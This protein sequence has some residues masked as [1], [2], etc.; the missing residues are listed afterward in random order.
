M[1]FKI[2]HDKIYQDLPPLTS[3]AFLSLLS[4]ASAEALPAEVLARAFRALPPLHENSKATLTR[5]LGSSEKYPYMNAVL[6]LARERASWLSAAEGEAEDLFMDTIVAITSSLREPRGRF[7]ET[8]WI[9]YSKQ[10]FEDAWRERF[11]RTGARR[12]PPTTSLS[13]SAD[14]ADVQH[15]EADVPSDS[16]I[17][18]HGTLRPDMEQ[19]LVDFIARQFATC[20]DERLRQVALDQF[21]GRPPSTLKTLGARVGLSR[22][23]IMRLVKRAQLLLLEALRRQNERELDLSPFE[24]RIPR[25]AALTGKPAIQGEGEP[26]GL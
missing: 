15:Q 13:H 19:W 22:F 12:D 6:A 10:R 5:L 11:G 2:G 1:P 21:L 26:H 23:Q 18:W 14:G 25:G 16:H 9:A 24:A 8:S 4:A 3:P 7:A 17:A 20:G